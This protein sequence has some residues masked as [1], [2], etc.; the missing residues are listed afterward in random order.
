MEALRLKII[1]CNMG[2]ICSSTVP[3]DDHI[4]LCCYS[5]DLEPALRN[6]SFVAGGGKRIGI[7]GRTGSGKSSTIMALFRAMD[8]S[9]VSGKIL[10][11][12]VDISTVP[13]A[14]LRNSIRC[15]MARVSSP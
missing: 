8:Q 1:P 9:L 11:D 13:L 5:E 4:E 10:L 2:A 6:V 14:T 7:C 15:V 3:L 12:G